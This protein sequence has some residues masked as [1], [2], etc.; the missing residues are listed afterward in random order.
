MLAGDVQVG[1]LQLTHACVWQESEQ[2]D[3][4]AAGVYPLYFVYQGKGK[5]DLLRF[6]L[7]K[8]T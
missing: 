1:E 6:T 3:F 2:L 7:E 8:R 5:I 4:Y